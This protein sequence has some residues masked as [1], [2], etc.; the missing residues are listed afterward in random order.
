MPIPIT[1]L[2][3]PHIRLATRDAHK[4]RGYFGNLFREHSPLL[5]NHLEGGG[6]RYAY[7]LVQYKVIRG[8]P[9]LVGISEGARLL[10]DLFLQISELEID[11]DR[12]PLDHKDL[13]CREVEA[14]YTED[15]H[16]YRFVT[17]W[18]ALNQDNYRVY[19]SLSIPEQEAKLRQ[20][21]RNHVLAAF[22]GMNIWLEPSQRIL[23]QVD[24]ATRSARFKDQKMITFSGT[25]TTN[26][27]LPRWIGLGKSVSRGFGTVE[28]SRP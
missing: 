4:L 14:G 28:L 2:T 9:A 8:V 22:K 12:F 19:Q 3:F 17:Q 6:L 5:H 25:F 18:M 11:G 15:L 24:L 20:V 16:C 21:L 7:P 26:A 13:K 10:V 23:T 27:L 1:T